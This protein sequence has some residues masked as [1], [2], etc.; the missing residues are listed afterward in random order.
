MNTTW[1]KASD[2][3]AGDVIVADGGFDCL[4]AGAHVVEADTTGLFVRCSSGTHHLD[5]QLNGEGRLVGF[6]A[7]DQ[8][9]TAEKA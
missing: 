9:I 6:T 3:K 1:V 2:V 8:L 4:S 7:D 5:G